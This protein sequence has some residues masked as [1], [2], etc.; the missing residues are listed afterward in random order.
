[1]P[2]P[3]RGGETA[4]AAADGPPSASM[5]TVRSAV[6]HS[7][8]PCT[9]RQSFICHPPVEHGGEMP[10]VTWHL[11][12]GLPVVP[13]FCDAV[14]VILYP[15]QKFLSESETSG[16]QAPGLS[17]RSPPCRPLPNCLPR[18]DRYHHHP[19]EYP[20]GIASPQLCSFAAWQCIAGPDWAAPK[21][22]QAFGISVTGEC[23]KR[24]VR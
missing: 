6:C 18:P 11:A 24:V 20:P 12:L 21:H 14:I 4:G 10:L 8:R 19:V 3:G 15:T 9:S 23:D 5:V 7:S 13:M 17:G 22:S 2:S 16:S 1:M